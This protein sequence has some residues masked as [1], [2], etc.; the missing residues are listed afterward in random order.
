[1]VSTRL[2]SRSG[3]GLW[4]DVSR[5]TAS[6]D[7]PRTT[8]SPIFDLM[9]TRSIDVREHIRGHANAMVPGARTRRIQHYRY[10]PET[11]LSYLATR[12]DTTL[13]R[14]TTK[15]FSSASRLYLAWVRTRLRRSSRALAMVSS[16]SSGV[17]KSAVST[18]TSS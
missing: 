9:R 14:L 4:P 6:L 16:A 8:L 3:H 5:R 10:W 12:T 1:M 7:S 13:A 15:A 17:L 11:S 2:G 18:E